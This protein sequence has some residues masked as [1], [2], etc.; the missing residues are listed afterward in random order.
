[1]LFEINFNQGRFG[2]KLYNIF[3]AIDKAFIMKDKIFFI[4]PFGVQN[5]FNIKNTYKVK[6][7]KEFRVLNDLNYNDS[8]DKNLV[9]I[10]KNLGHN[11]F[12][13][14]TKI[15]DF[16]VIKN[17][18]LSNR[19]NSKNFNVAIHFRGTDFYQWNPNSILPGSYYIDSI[20]IFSKDRNAHFFLYTD[21]KNLKSYRQV[22]SFLKKHEYKFTI[23]ENQKHFIYDFAEMANCNAVISS[24]STFCIWASVL[25]SKKVVVQNKNWVL[26]CIEEGDKFWIELFEGKNKT[27][28]EV[29]YYV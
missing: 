15:K 18:F 1:M 22:I 14:K 10:G 26:R 9:F 27:N 20:K 11:F 13:V 25:G 23:G 17:K 7:H 29:N 28:Y 21:D 5:Y 24:P 4:N 19:L 16:L 2:N 6:F 12:S 3:Y 8:R